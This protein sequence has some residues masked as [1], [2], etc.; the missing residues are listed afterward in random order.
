MDLNKIT[1]KQTQETIDRICA[2]KDSEENIEI[3]SIL[4]LVEED[5]TFTYK[6]LLNSRLNK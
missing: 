5:S 6:E 3:F 1:Y 4:R 2:R